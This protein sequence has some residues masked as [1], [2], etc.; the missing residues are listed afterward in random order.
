MR[1]AVGKARSCHVID[2]CGMTG[3]KERDGHID[4]GRQPGCGLLHH[5]CEPLRRSRETKPRM[6][7]TAMDQTAT[8]IPAEIAVAAMRPTVFRALFSIERVLRIDHARK[9]R[10]GNHT[11][12]S[13]VGRTWGGPGRYDTEPSCPCTENMPSGIF[14]LARRHHAVMEGYD[15]R[16]RLFEAFADDAAVAHA[17]D[18]NRPFRLL[19]PAGLPPCGGSSH[20]S[21]AF[22]QP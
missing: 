3:G 5:G 11:P 9:I 8:Q 18:L 1:H 2:E 12:P 13:T 22:Q 6:T 10:H 15:S 16:C 19:E 20:M 4:H 17:R 14:R 21:G 7:D